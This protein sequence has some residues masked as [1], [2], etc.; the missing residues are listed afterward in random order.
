M[1]RGWS[2]A[3]RR[4][5][6]LAC[7]AAAAS[8]PLLAAD[9]K[10]VAEAERLATLAVSLS[11]V[12]PPEA[13]EKAG[14]ALELSAD[15]E[16]TA[17]VASGRKGEVVEDAYLAARADYRRHRALLYHA[18]G[19]ALAGAGRHTAAVRY[20]RR[21][22]ELDATPRH[23]AA[24]AR[25]LIASGRPRP[26][27]EVLLAS[28][29]RLTEE[30]LALS[31]AA[32]DAAELP[33]LQAEIDRVRLQA[34]P[35]G[36]RPEL[37]DGRFRL[38]DRTRLS[39]GVPADLEQDGVTI[40]Y[41]SEASCRSCSADMLAIRRSAPREARIL[42]S[43]PSRELDRALRQAMTLYRHDWPV[44]VGG[45]ADQAL[46]LGAPSIFVIARGGFLGALLRPPF[47]GLPA[48]LE[49]L[50]KADVA[51]GVP[52]AAW[53]RR[54]VDRRPAPARPGLLP[55]GLAPAED[56]PA[57]EAF[58]SAVA[59]YR[60]GRFAEAL[61]LFQQLE[62]EGE[63]WLLPPEGRLD[64]ALCL[65]GIGRREEARLLM[66]RT[67]DSRFQD[68]VDQ[69]LERA[70]SPSRKPSSSLTCGGGAR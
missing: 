43:A 65:I 2:A 55:E 58:V 25:S 67:G 9:A 37:R 47:L 68:A 34:L 5:L 42:V 17:F 48:V 12:N 35:A 13:L 69:V 50:T 54:P 1:S 27:L 7:G 28:G 38:P 24:L 52:R 56:E 26:A 61:R 46:G 63:G 30:A 3:R 45:G 36:Q 70:G 20:L 15:F 32:A 60:A 41:S 16:P 19:L 49:A 18:Q 10:A 66:L 39:T 11:G 51:E 44:V 57:P 8:F 23:A 62:N 40:L 64:R 33:S 29:E 6:V 31:A 53:N 22:Q 4:V 59:A 21:A 14:Q